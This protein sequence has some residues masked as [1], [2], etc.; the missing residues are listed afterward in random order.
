M[1]TPKPLAE[2]AV[3]Y[4]P[5]TIN[6]SPAVCAQL[7]RFAR[8]NNDLYTGWATLALAHEAEHA[9]LLDGWANETLTE[10]R[11]MKAMPQLL[12]FLGRTGKPYAKALRFA[13]SIHA[14]FRMFPGYGSAPCD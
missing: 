13:T 5:D 6:L 3:F 4:Y 7:D 14:S 1:P 12:T 10:C 2:S 9:S 8:G 11:A